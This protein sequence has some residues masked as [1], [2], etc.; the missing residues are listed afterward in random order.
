M[1]TVFI[2]G[3]AGYIGTLLVERLLKRSD[4]Q[5]IICLDKKEISTITDPKVVFISANL[6]ESEKWISLVSE[7][8][9]N[10]VIHTAW[11]IR[12]MRFKSKLQREW[13][14]EGSQNV[15]DFCF[16]NEFVK[17]LVHYSTVAS[18]GAFE[19]NTFEDIFSED[20]PL[21]MCGYKYADEKT[22][23]ETLLAGYVCE[24][25]SS[26]NVFV[27]RPASITGPSIKRIKTD[28]NLQSI[29]RGS[30]KKSPVM[31]FIGKLFS[32]FLATKGWVRQFVHEDDVISITELLAFWPEGDRYEIVNASPLGTPTFAPDMARLV[33]KKLVIVPAFIIRLIFFILWNSSLGKIPTSPGGWKS[34]SYP[35]LVDGKKV[36]NEFDYHYQYDS[37]RAFLDAQTEKKG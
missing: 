1:N 33:S 19:T 7:Y 12:E 27:I 16:N 29:L 34:F 17:T 2:T 6:S 14:I 37:E 13:N 20:D 26:K 5:K 23:V 10:I 30:A 11:Q 15:F 8:K 4:I 18:Y 21:R 24:H 9:P 25:T 28:F 36:E 32:V 35:I 31:N 22:E 3:S